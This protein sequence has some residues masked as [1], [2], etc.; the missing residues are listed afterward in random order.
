M[1]VCFFSATLHTP[2][3]TQLADKICDKPTWVDLKGNAYHV[4]ALL[5]AL[6]VNVWPLPALVDRLVGLAGRDSV[7][8]TVH[9]VVVEVR[10]RHS[11]DRKMDLL[12]RSCVLFTPAMSSS[13]HHPPSVRPAPVPPLILLTDL[14]IHPVTQVDPSRYESL[15][16]GD[17]ASLV[18]SDD[19]HPGKPKDPAEAQSDRIKRCERGGRSSSQ[20]LTECHAALT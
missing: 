18:S 12:S 1:Q 20:Q 4:H 10:A 7:P 16:G 8:E 2:E 19:V 14:P 5:H 6:S 9:H 13:T 3:I 11:Q 17:K 15:L